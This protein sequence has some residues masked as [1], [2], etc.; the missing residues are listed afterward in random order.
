M[1]YIIEIS[2]IDSEEVPMYLE[3]LSLD[4]SGFGFSLTSNTAEAHH[5]DDEDYDWLE[6]L[7]SVLHELKSPGQSI[8]IVELYI[9]GS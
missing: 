7:A 8:S 3:N 1:K 9:K 2:E 4:C 6:T 5:Y